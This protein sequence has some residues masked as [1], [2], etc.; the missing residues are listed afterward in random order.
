MSLPQLNLPPCQLTVRGDKVLD[1][2]R[3]RFV[4]LTPEEWVRQHVVHLLTDVMMYPRELV[5]TEGTIEVNGLARRC[6]IVVHRKA[7]EGLQPVMIVECKAPSVPLSQKVLDQAS[8]YNL[9]LHVSHLFITNG[10][11]HLLFRIDE[12]KRQLV[13]LGQ[14][15]A[16]EDL[17]G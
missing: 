11:R 15:P 10:M 3:H 13:Q 14:F 17:A 16:W 12:G 4:A 8:R 1:V 7:D 5:Q 6:D 9:A 2:L